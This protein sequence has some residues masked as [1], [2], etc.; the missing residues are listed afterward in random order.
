MNSF[1]RN[2]YFYLTLATLV[3][4]YFPLYPNGNEEH[5][6][7]FSSNLEN[8]NSNLFYEFSPLKV[9][10][11]IIIGKSI[12]L[13]GFNFTF[14]LFRLIL[15]LGFSM[16]F[17]DFVLKTLRK[18]LLVLPVVLVFI[19]FFNQSFFG[20]SW[21]LVS[22]EPKSFSWLFVIFSLTQ[23]ISDKK[24]FIIPLIF[25]FIFHPLIGVQVS[26]LYIVFVL[27]V[28]S[29]RRHLKILIPFFAF[30]VALGLYYIYFEKGNSELCDY[31]YIY[32]ELRVPHHVSLLANLKGF[33][34]SSLLGTLFSV[35]LLVIVSRDFVSPDKQLET[36]LIIILLAQL[37]AIPLLEIERLAPLKKF[38]PYRLNSLAALIVS[39]LTFKKFVMDGRFLLVLS[40]F[41]STTFAKQTVLESYYLINDSDFFAIIDDLNLLSNEN[42]VIINN[43]G[44]LDVQRNTKADVFYEWKFIP[45]SKSNICLWHDKKTI[46]EA[47]LSGDGL[48][49]VDLVLTVDDLSVNDRFE[50]LKKRG[51]Y[52]IYR[53]L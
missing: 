4:T 45:T 49:E 2:K 41:A 27:F 34:F 24:T 16:A 36:L 33:L 23:F 15:I 52:R 7:L 14:I 48:E 53:G 44:R 8:S 6:L 26:C 29:Y 11:D 39:V 18:D 40:V 32:N 30:C 37:L 5:Y 9:V 50:L 13:I 28:R 42:T 22:V 3:V 25:A 31:N 19:A 20:G 12:K 47:K 35:A 38:Y 1:Y 17:F 10:Y 21:M 51:N 46:Q 43:T